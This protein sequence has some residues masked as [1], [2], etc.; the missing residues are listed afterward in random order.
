MDIHQ[1]ELL[2]ELVLQKSFKKAAQRCFVTTSTLTRQV[3]AMETELGFPIFIRS[4]YGITLTEQGEVF[5][6]E[7]R[8][9]VRKYKAAVQN[10]R[11]ADSGHR[12]IRVGTYSYI[13]K[14][15]T[16]VCNDLKRQYP[17]ISFSFSSCRFSDSCSLLHSHNADLIMLGETQEADEGIFC[18]PVFYAY[19]IVITSVQH[20]L[21]ERKAVRAEE[22]NGHTILLPKLEPHHRNRRKM[23]KLFSASCPGSEILEFEHPDQADAMCMMNEAVISSISLL[24]VD[25]GMHQIRIT[26]APKV[27]IGIMCR[28]ED[29]EHLN[30]VMCSCRDYFRK[31]SNRERLELIQP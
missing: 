25:E 16:D 31:N 8:G 3:T 9:I 29:E 22:L 19:N 14:Q 12:L 6:R 30:P 17:Y 1:L 28:A 18:M 15:I 27:E 10:A 24:D 20:P 7:T 23:K 2:D 5:Y 21:A 4:S 11:S 26:D 13:K